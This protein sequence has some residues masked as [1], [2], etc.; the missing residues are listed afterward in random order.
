VIGSVVK[1]AVLPD[2]LDVGQTL[3]DRLVGSISMVSLDGVEVHGFFDDEGVVDQSEGLV[4]DGGPELE[5][6]GTVKQSLQEL[7]DLL[8]L[9]AAHE[10]AGAEVFTRVH[11]D[12]SSGI[13]C[14]TPF[15]CYNLH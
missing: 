14:A 9:L 2:Q 7:V 3:L 12:K 13:I 15:L 11:V 1:L 8:V 6:V 4:V 10:G 5:G